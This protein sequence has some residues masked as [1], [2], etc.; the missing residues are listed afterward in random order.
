MAYMIDI[1]FSSSTSAVYLTFTHRLAEEKV[2]PG[3]ICVIYLK[4]Y[5]VDS[6]LDPSLS[7]NQLDCID[8]THYLGQWTLC[9]TLDA[10]LYL[11]VLMLHYIYC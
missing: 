7:D 3:S 9:H 4:R 1:F 6:L 8:I 5:G 2:L 10:P 11:S